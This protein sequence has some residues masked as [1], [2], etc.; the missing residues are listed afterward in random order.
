MSK[1]KPTAPLLNVFFSDPH[2]GSDVGLLVP[3]VDLSTGNSVNINKNSWQGWL[4]KCFLDFQNKVKTIVGNEPYIVTMG[5]DTIEGAHHGTDELVA[6]KI[7]DHLAIAK[8][9]FTPLVSKAARVY[10]VR[11]TECH[12]RDLETAL[13]K[14]WNREYGNIA[15]NRAH[16]SIQ[17]E[18]NGCLYDVRHHMPTSGRKW[19]EMNALG[20]IAHN[21]R[22]NAL[23]AG[24]EPARIFLRAHRHINGNIDDGDIMVAVCGAWQ[25]LTRHGNKVVTD[26]V[27]RPSFIILDHRHKEHGQLPTVHKFVYNP[28]KEVVLYSDK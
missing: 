28:P 6:A 7:Q 3:D 26:S 20:A 1:R 15:G 17:Y 21:N 18:L 16:D 27:C 12:V 2:C 9:A 10:M 13:A 11:G 23:A 19:L 4:Y 14:E 5:G 8:A 22:L 24:H 25:G